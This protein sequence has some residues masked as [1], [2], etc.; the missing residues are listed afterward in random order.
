MPKQQKI[1][2]C[3]WFHDRAEEA[4]DFYAS[5]LPDSKVLELTRWGPGGPFPEG[6]LLSAR[7]QLCGQ[8]F[9][10]L[11]GAPPQASFTEATSLC[12]SCE[13]QA[14]V[15]ELWEE[16]GAGGQPGQC[17]WLKDRYGLSWQVVPSVLGEMLRDEDPARLGRVMQAML[18]MTKLDI[19]RLRRAYEQP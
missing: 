12:V 13:T 3:L 4:I 8:E 10:V 9:L 17:G 18:Q 14:E 11:S 15:D 7:L 5:I 16:L 1:T 2:T 6:T 19:A